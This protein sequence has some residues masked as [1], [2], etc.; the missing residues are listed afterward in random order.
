MLHEASAADGYP[1]GSMKLVLAADGNIYG[2]GGQSTQLSPPFFIYRLTP[3]GSYS[4]LLTF[5]GSYGVAHGA[6]LIAAS[7]GN[8][9]GTFSGS[10]TNNSGFIYQ[11]TLAG[12]WQTV[13][14]FPPIGSQDGMARTGFARRSI[15]SCPLRGHRSQCHLPLRSRNPRADPRLS[16]EHQQPARQLR[17]MQF[18]T[19]HGWQTVW[20]GANR[21]TRRGRGIQPRLRTPQA[22][23]ISRSVN[24]RLGFRRAEGSAMGI[25]PF[26]RDLGKI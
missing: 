22:P 12:Q 7:D 19:G 4:H 21:W 2:L 13:A 25:A 26:G 23:S 20:D 5:P 1:T 6:S 8:L 24:A 3:A 17:P 15:R 14:N 11:A 9:Y 10:G 18:H 16:N